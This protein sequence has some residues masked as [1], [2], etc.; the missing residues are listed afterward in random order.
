MSFQKLNFG[1]RPATQAAA[2]AAPATAAN[3][4]TA[5]VAY[6]NVYLPL[7]GGERARIGDTGIPLRA[8]KP[9]EAALLEALQNGSVTVEQLSK[10][11]LLE[12]G[13]PRDPNVPLQLDLSGL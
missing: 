5:P 13:Q 12:I 8:D 6:I 2:A 11:L 3:G 7:A 4:R 1:T 9:A 10:L